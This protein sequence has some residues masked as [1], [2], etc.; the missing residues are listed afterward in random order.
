MPPIIDMC[1]IRYPIPRI[2]ISSPQLTN[3]SAVKNYISV[4]W[5]RATLVLAADSGASSI[6]SSQSTKCSAPKLYM[7]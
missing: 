5:T 6:F 4:T 2:K 7:S 1:K 3:D